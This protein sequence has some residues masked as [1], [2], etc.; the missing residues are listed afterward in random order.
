LKKLLFNNRIRAEKVR[1]I[2]P[3]G[4]QI[5][6]VGLEEALR[7]AK[8]RGLDLIQVSEKTEPPVCKI[9]DYG[10]YLYSQQKKNK[11]KKAGLLKTIRLT[12]NISEH[13]LNTKVKQ[14]RSFLEKG[15]KIRAEMVLRG[16][17]KALSGFAKE[18]LK[19][20]LEILNE[21]TP[22]KVERQLKKEARGLT[23]IIT[24]D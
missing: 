11:A 24:K 9:M 12:F 16:R 14:A 22:I 6:I 19:Q 10:K 23:I 21:K 1:L 17:Q 7:L 5:G 20:F 3:T 18:K 15:N 13:D 2:D 8:E 4:K